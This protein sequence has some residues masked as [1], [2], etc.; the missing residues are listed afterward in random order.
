MSDTCLIKIDLNTLH[1]RYKFAGKPSEEGLIAVCDEND[2]WFHITCDLEPAY[3]NR[4]TWVG[5]FRNGKATASVEKKNYSIDVRGNIL[6]NK[7][8]R[9]ALTWSEHDEPQQVIV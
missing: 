1:T 7:T 8:F 3:K 2:L 4:F 6:H 5:R 9:C